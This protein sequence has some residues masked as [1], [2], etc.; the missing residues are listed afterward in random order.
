MVVVWNDKG[1]CVLCI[2]RDQIRYLK[3]RGEQAPEEVKEALEK[4]W[5]AYKEFIHVIQ[6]KDYWF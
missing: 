1:E 5:Q 6:E 2:I 4:L 3:R